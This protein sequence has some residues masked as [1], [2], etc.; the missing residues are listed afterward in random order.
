MIHGPKKWQGLAPRSLMLSSVLLL[1]LPR[2]RVACGEGFHRSFIHQIKILGGGRCR[3]GR[4]LLVA[5]FFRRLRLRIHSDFLLTTVYHAGEE[6]A[7]NSKVSQTE[8]KLTEM[9]Q[10][11][12]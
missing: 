5:D 3:R 11:E 12:A 8:W 7:S 4:F 10:R 9:N 6:E 1:E 2:R